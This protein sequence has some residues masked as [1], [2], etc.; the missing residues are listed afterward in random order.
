M[1][2]RNKALGNM[3]QEITASIQVVGEEGRVVTVDE[4][5]PS[6]RRRE[7]GRAVIEA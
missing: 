7:L 5:D 1:V 4:P 3:A 6:F 2:A